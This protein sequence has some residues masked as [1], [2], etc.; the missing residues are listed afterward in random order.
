MMKFRALLL[1]VAAAPA[2][3]AG[4][5][6]QCEKEA[7][8]FGDGSGRDVISA[9]CVAHVSRSARVQQR[10][11]GPVSGVRAA[12][13]ETI[14]LVQDPKSKIKGQNLIA[15]KYTDLADGVAALAI[16]EKHRELAALTNSGDVQFYSIAVTG[17]V[18]P[19]RTIRHK[20]LDG[21]TAVAVNGEAGHV[22]VLNGKKQEVLV[23]P[24][25]ANFH[26]QEGKKKLSPVKIF[27][28]VAG[29]E[30]VV[31]DDALLVV[32]L[33]GGGVTVVDLATSTVRA[34]LKIPTDFAPV[35]IVYDGVARSLNL[36]S[37]TKVHRVL[38][39][40]APTP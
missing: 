11:R 37:G 8:R 38:I 5:S 22:Y 40:K 18:A 2:L 1:V 12:G 35:E 32:D 21:G 29:E 31:A 25:T 4:L 24:R 6:G 20:E 13:A 10:K 19:L 23:F 39:P 7:R 3:A 27:R 17:N 14:I 28:D 26:S 9:E 16:D 15:G 33:G 36:V 30:L 34:R